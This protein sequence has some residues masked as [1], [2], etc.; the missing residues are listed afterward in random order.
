MTTAAEPPTRSPADPPAVSRFEYNLLRLLRFVLGHMPADQAV[1]LVNAKQ[2][3]PACLSRT[4]V[5]LAKDMLAK[6]AVIHLVRAGG[7][8]RERFL[9]GNHPTEGRVWERHPLDERRLSFG[10]HVLSFL[11]WLTAEKPSDTKENWDANATEL[12][13]ADEWFFALA[14][15]AL[16][17]VP[18]AFQAVGH[19]A[20]FRR[21]PLCWLL[22]PG[23]F[24]GAEEPT[25]P[26]FEPWTHGTR[27]VVLECLQPA[28]TQRWVRA[29]RA[30]GQLGDWRK[31]RQQGRAELACL[32]AFLTAVEAAKRPDL[33]RFVL[34]AASAILSAGELT[35]AFW[36]GGL[37]GTGPP[38]LADRLETQRAALA[39]PRQMETLQHW[40]RAARSVGYFDEEYAASQ[41]WKAD[42]E[43]AQGERIAAA[44]RRVIEQLEPLRT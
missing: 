20:V 19:K 12:S 11:S 34:R 38:R 13:A 18:E 41:L 25:P 26:N 2:P 4:C 1:L 28:L 9:R 43:S 36:T 3:P 27:A 35:P 8:R 37:Q 29:E 21:N 23:D 6:G 7:W 24:A 44:A 10:P 33:A 32:S 16:R 30:K 31:M 17:Q 39:L 5:R 15:D 40:D 22:S 14:F 42:W